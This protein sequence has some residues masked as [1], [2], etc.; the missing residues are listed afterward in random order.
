M[1]LQQPT[2]YDP[3][4][5]IGQ[6]LKSVSEGVTSTWEPIIQKRINDYNTV[7]GELDNIEK[8]KSELSVYH[9]DILTKKAE[10]LQR[11]T[12]GIIRKNE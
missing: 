1:A 10:E 9:R 3:S 11:D 7:K 4:K 12:A 5:K 6:S 8:I 2:I